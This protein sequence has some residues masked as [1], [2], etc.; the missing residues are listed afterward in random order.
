MHILRKCF[1][2]FLLLMT[3]LCFGYPQMKGRQMEQR[4]K[5]AVTDVQ[6][7]TIIKTETPT[8]TDNTSLQPSE[9]VPNLNT[10]IV[11]SDTDTV[12]PNLELLQQAQHYNLNLF[13]HVQSITD[14]WSGTQDT[15][16]FP[17]LSTQAF[18]A[19]EIPDMGVFMPLYL[20]ATD[21]N[22]NQG[23]AVLANTS[24]PIGGR[25]TNSVIAG[26]RGWYG[27]RYFQD[28]QRLHVGSLIYLHNPWGTLTYR[29]VGMSI[30]DPYDVD[31]IKIQPDKDM[32]TLL[33]CHPVTLTH[34]GAF[35]YL[36]FCE[37]VADDVITPTTEKMPLPYEPS[38]SFPSKP[39]EP[40]SPE[41]ALVD[42]EP[43]LQ[44]I[45]PVILLVLGLF[46]LL[47]PNSKKR[48]HSC[49]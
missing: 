47:T 21:Q 48:S 9:E 43:I 15:T 41:S 46:L 29:A 1:G 7:Q 16:M 10:E 44:T 39:I 20:G 26:H 45:L 23:A 17:A 11:S 2:V 24:I 27:S 36:V 22:L 40:L 34:G 6:T 3:L 13:Q 8:A 37:R 28:I 4:A 42:V 14:A 19:I 18:G 12:L 25:N 38:E 30:I 32:I 31:A 35:R 5:Q 49:G 33:T